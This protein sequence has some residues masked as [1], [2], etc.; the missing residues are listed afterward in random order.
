[1]VLD[2]S[3][4]A[5]QGVTLIELMITVAIIGIISAVALPIYR[6]YVSTAQTAVIENN[7]QTIRLLQ[8]ERRLSFGEYA[9]GVHIPGGSTTLTANLGWNPDSSVDVI[10][11]TVTCATDGTKAGECA[12]NSGYTVVGSHAN[13][14]L[15]TVTR[16]YVP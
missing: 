15:E 9:E 7:I 14:P 6:D 10:T 8:E 3:M 1:M 5:Q 16:S 13:A 2:T 4:R 12:R 11:Y